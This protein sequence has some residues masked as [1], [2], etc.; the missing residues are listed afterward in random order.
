MTVLTENRTDLLRAHAL[1]IRERIV[2]VCSNPE[3]GHLG[4]SL[5]LVEVLTALYFDVLRIDP[6]HPDDPHRDIF[7]L[8]KGHAAIGLYSTLAERGFVDPAE[9][10]G[11]GTTGSRFMA[12]PV[13]SIPGVEMPTGSL[14][15]GP[16][17]AIGFALAA[18]LSGSRRRV[19]VALGD[20]EL[21][22]GSVWEAAMGAAGLG[23]DNLIAVVDRNGLQLTG[24]TEDICPLEPLGDRWRSFGWAVREV[25]GQNIEA[26]RDALA[27]APWMPGRPSVLIARTTKG[28]GVPFV[29]G[30]PKSHYVNFSERQQA[31]ARIALRRAAP[32]EAHHG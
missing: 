19:F 5:S 15:H 27:G 21:Q 31:R 22:E 20:G 6:A 28:A 12:H 11:Y 9:L 25:D 3:G 17:L 30:N 7:L 14:G 4:G 10:A 8:S 1:N 32:G 2:D 29:A 26:V 18:K 16:A 13:R 24:S 23:L